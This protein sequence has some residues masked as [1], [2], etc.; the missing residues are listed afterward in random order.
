MNKYNVDANLEA[1]DN[2]ISDNE[3]PSEMLI[4]QSDKNRMS[5]NRSSQSV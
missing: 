3:P 2:V 5:Q 4:S 1:Y